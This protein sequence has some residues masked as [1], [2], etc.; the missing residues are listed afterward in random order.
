MSFDTF[1]PFSISATT[2]RSRYEPL[3]HEP[4]KT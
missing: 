3:V 4:M 2:F 1:F